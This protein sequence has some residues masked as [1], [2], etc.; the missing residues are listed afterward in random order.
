V[1]LDSDDFL[2][3]KPSSLVI[4]EDADGDGDVVMVPLE[5]RMPM[6]TAS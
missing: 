3:V 2:S 1:V 5:V 4:D 6:S